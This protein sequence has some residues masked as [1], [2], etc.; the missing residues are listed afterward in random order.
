[1]HFQKI[2]QYGLGGHGIWG[3]N[4]FDPACQ[5]PFNIPS[6]IVVPS[7]F[8]RSAIVMMWRHIQTVLAFFK[9]PVVIL[10]IWANLSIRDLLPSCCKEGVQ[11]FSIQSDPF[12][13]A[14][15][16]CTDNKKLL[17]IY[18]IGLVVLCK[19]GATNPDVSWMR[20]KV[21]RMS[22]ATILSHLSCF[23]TY[24]I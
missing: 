1:M 7:G 9:M 3:H 22:F 10:A 13:Y 21:T 23:N 14:N 6:R 20:S 16:A 12:I 8:T 5:S 4:R 18:P 15:L 24:G 2:A 17:S 19:M 11:A